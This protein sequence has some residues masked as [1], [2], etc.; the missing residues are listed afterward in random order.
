MKYKHKRKIKL[1]FKEQEPLLEEKP[2]PSSLEENWLLAGLCFLTLLLFGVLVHTVYSMFSSPD[3]IRPSE[4]FLAFTI[5]V[6]LVL[7]VKMILTDL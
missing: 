6:T 7:K 2:K 3:T 1:K 5:I 4:V